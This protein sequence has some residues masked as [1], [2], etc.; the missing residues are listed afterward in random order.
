M[1]YLDV[2]AAKIKQAV[3]P[4]ALP[5]EEMSD[6]FLIYAVLLLAKGRDVTNEDV[7]NGWVAWM[8]SKGKE[9]E[10]MVP[11]TSLSKNTQSE[12]S[13]FVKAIRKVFEQSD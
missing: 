7:H 12:D 8:E 13:P 5:D 6:L 2:I 9:H 3:S 4:E 10:S 11:F 1:T